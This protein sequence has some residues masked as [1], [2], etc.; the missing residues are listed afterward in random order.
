MASR[1]ASRQAAMRLSWSSGVPMALMSA[2]MASSGRGG[3]RSDAAE[4]PGEFFTT[5][6][7]AACLS[8]PMVSRSVCTMSP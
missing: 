8:A 6:I 4:P 1:S 7:N 5:D 2:S 3:T